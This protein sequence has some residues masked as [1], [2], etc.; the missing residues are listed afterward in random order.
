[1]RLYQ[2]IPSN[3]KTTLI[4]AS[5]VL[6]SLLCIRYIDLQILNYDK[7]QDRA[8][9]NSIRQIILNAP[10]GIIF[11]RN[12]LPLVDNRPTYDLMIIPIDVT[13]KFDYQLLSNNIGMPS[14]KLKKEINKGKKSIAR[15]RPK[16][17]KRHVNFE[18]MSILEEYKM[19]LPGIIFSENPART[20]VS[21][22]NISHALGYLR[23]VNDKILKN[24]PTGMNYLI[25]DV[26]GAAG[27]EKMYEPYLRGN[28]GLEYHRVDI[29]SRDHG[30]VSD[31]DRYSPKSG[32]SLTIT[33]DSQLQS[34]VESKI[35]GHRGAVIA[36]DPT[37]GE[38][39]VFASA[40]DYPLKSF[41]GPI[42]TDLW[43]SLNTDT[44]RPL[45]N[46]G[47]NGLYPPGST[48]KLVAA[49]LIMESEL[50]NPYYKVQ[51][52]GVYT[53]GDRDFHCWNLAGHGQMNLKSAI[54]HSCNI[55]FYKVIQGLIFSQWSEMAYGF[56]YGKKTGI[57]LPFES[58]G[59]VPTESYLNEKYTRRGWSTGNLL[60][61]V[62]GQGDVLSTPLQV[63]QMI[64]L[65]STKGHTFQ[66]HLNMQLEKIPVNLEL[67]PK[68]WT[69]LQDALY[70]VVNEPDGTGRN[71]K[72]QHGGKIWGK[73]GTS[74]NPHGDHHSSFLG[75]MTT[76]TGKIFTL[77][78]IVENGG[79]GSEIA[80]SLARDIFNSYANS[81]SAIAVN[82]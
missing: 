3:R 80:S 4:S 61:F 46:R 40:P 13:E 42:P 48:F 14:E 66:P 47:I 57:D 54:K 23:T 70:D 24:A 7:Y 78:I 53:L 52:N 37:T 16:L 73:T 51:C 72:I 63:L 9:S 50:I 6:M 44:N 38:V 30:V 2:P 36:M 22:S 67:N 59:I 65:I 56:G 79:K 69:F 32:Q 8:N 15:F 81:Q 68:T 39:L 62:I 25:D 55:Y 64:N 21:D 45:F 74:Q 75:Y 12:G 41:V 18:I 33:I 27:L 49:S 82:D 26:Y 60:S 34:F 10:R 11:D 58:E 1:M 76:E 71:A 19:S 28:N 77:Y 31:E 5:V 20:Y 29:Y 17:I 35:E 43:G